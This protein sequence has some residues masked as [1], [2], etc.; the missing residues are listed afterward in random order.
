MVALAVSG[1]VTNDSGLNKLLTLAHEEDYRSLEVQLWYDGF[2]KS[3]GC[4]LG[5][6]LA[7]LSMWFWCHDLRCCL[8]SSHHKQ[9]NWKIRAIKS[10]SWKFILHFCFYIVGHKWVTETHPAA[11]EAGIVVFVCPVM[12]PAGNGASIR[13]EKGWVESKS[14]EPSSSFCHI[15]GVCNLG[16]VNST[17]FSNNYILL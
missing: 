16:M 6:W 2:T 3:S 8:S 15:Q 7:F 5:C 1:K 12:C 11:M 17:D 14:Q 10:V 4:L 13:G 9:K